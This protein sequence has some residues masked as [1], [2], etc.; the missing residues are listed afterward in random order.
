MFCIL[1]VMMVITKL[2]IFFQTHETG[3]LMWVNVNVGKLCS[4]MLIFLKG[5]VSSFI[6][7]LKSTEVPKVSGN[8]QKVS[9][10]NLLYF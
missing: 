5:T 7:F 6:P 9:T 3:H 8:S 4:I 1:I 10:S 2:C